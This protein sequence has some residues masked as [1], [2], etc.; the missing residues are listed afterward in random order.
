MEKDFINTLLERFPAQQQ[1]IP[2]YA[3]ISIFIYPWTILAVFKSLSVY[4]ILFLRP[5]DILSVVAYLLLNDFVET[6]LV[7]GLLLILSGLLPRRALS[8]QFVVNGTIITICFLG[9]IVLY[10]QFFKISQLL[11]DFPYWLI[12]FL[13][14]TLLLLFAARKV[15]AVRKTVEFIAD[16][17]IVFLYLFLPLTLLSLL[18]VLARNVSWG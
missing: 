3:M 5:G 7:L 13:L 12:S 17:C 11:V 6:V 1:I 18:L 2:V 16:R 9:S 10:F 15:R 14:L 4:W 8:D